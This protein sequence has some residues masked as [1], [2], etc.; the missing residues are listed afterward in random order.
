MTTPIDPKK[1]G[2][3]KRKYRYVDEISIKLNYVCVM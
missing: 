1:K 2:K 3:G